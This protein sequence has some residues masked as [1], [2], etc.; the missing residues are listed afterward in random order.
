M[1]RI[2]ITETSPIKI[3]LCDDQYQ[4][5]CL[6]ATI[7]HARPID[8]RRARADFKLEKEPPEAEVWLPPLTELTP[9]ELEE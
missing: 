3:W 6:L 8:W 4:W 5:Q 9:E 2:R 7:E 1:P